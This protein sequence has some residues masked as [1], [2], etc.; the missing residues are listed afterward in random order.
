[1][2]S[3]LSTR[4]DTISTGEHGFNH[5]P[6]LSPFQ[7]ATQEAAVIDDFNRRHAVLLPH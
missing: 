5:Y 4:N 6:E 1:M 3:T 2:H 7:A